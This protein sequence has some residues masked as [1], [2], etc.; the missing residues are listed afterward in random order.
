MPAR[1]EVSR[2]QGRRE[3]RDGLRVGL[4]EELV[5]AATD[6]DQPVQVGGVDDV[7]APV[8]LAEAGPPDEWGDECEQLERAERLAEERFGAGVA[9]RATCFVRAA[10][11]DDRDLLRLWRL[12][13]PLQVEDAVD[14]GQPDIEQDGVR[15]RLGKHPLRL[16]HVVRRVHVEPFQLER[17]ADQLTQEPVV[18]D[19]QYATCATHLENPPSIGGGVPFPEVSFGRTAARDE[20]CPGRETVSKGEVFLP[21]S[22]AGWG[23]EFTL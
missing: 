13:Q 23:D 14:P 8:Q 7:G 1:A 22:P 17:G 18:I 10:D 5:L 16:D 3:D 11:R 12:T 9:R 2:L 21:K 4:D 6:L 19:D 15:A 20:D